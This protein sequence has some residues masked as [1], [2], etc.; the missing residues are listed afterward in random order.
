M[1]AKFFERLNFDRAGGRGVGNDDVSRQMLDR[2]LEL[3]PREDRRERV[4]RTQDDSEV[5]EE[6]AR[7]V[8]DDVQ[9]GYDQ[10]PRVCHK[11]KKS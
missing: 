4:L 3:T 2:G 7:K 8:G 9:S 5:T 10:G 6:G 1:P 11:N